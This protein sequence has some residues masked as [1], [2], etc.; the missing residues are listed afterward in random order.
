MG[1]TQIETPRNHETVEEDVG[2]VVEADEVATVND[3]NRPLRE[4]LSQ[5]IV[6]VKA[7]PTSG[8]KKPASET[9][10]VEM[11][12]EHVE[13]TVKP[14]SL[15]YRLPRKRAHSPTKLSQRKVV[16]NV[17]NAAKV[18]RRNHAKAMLA[19]Q[20]AGLP[21]DCEASSLKQRLQ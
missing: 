3:K 21:Q 18:S 19:R 12:G 20:V 9:K 10:P 2:D 8:D 14:F 17:P 16:E 15:R 1:R 11:P 5:P 7:K 4:I 13:K 6:T